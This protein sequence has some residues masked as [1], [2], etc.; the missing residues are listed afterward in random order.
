RRA[1]SPIPVTL[2]PT[3]A[4]KRPRSGPRWGERGSTRP[5]NRLWKQDQRP[6][7][8]PVARSARSE[9]R[10]SLT[11]GAHTPVGPG[12]NAAGQ[13]AGPGGRA[14]ACRPRPQCPAG[15]AGATVAFAGASQRPHAW[16]V[17]RN[18]APVGVGFW[19]PVSLAARAPGA[20]VRR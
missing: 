2:P 15:S 8:A 5:R 9:Q 17:G 4:K 19:S 11:G 14:H 7:P 18:A 3:G 1:Y 13:G 20:G 12:L 6:K 16:T 10:Q